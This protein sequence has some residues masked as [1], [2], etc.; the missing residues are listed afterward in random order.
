VT[1]IQ[2]MIKI[3]KICTYGITRRAVVVAIATCLF[4]PERALADSFIDATI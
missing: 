4:V 1:A 2:M 3:S